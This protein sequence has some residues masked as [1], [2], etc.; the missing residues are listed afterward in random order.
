VPARRSLAVIVVVVAI[1]TALGCARDAA[2]PKLV[3]LIS[4]DTLRRDAL[5]AFDQAAMPLPHVDA[6]A[7]ESVRFE[8]A[9]SVAS[10]TLPAHASM[11]TGLGPERHG[12][13]DPRVTL[14]TEV[15]TLAERFGAAG[16]ET[17]AITH[18]GYVDRRYGFGRGF[19]S[20][21]DEPAPAK[22][23]AD[24][25]RSVFDLAAELLRTR[26]DPR[27][28]F[29]FL[30]TYSVHDYF[31]LRPWAVSQVEEQPALERHEYAE[32]LQGKRLCKPSDWAYLR[33]LYAAELRTFDAA[34]G[35]LLAALDAAGLARDAVIALTTDHGEGFEAERGR[36]HHGGRLH[37][38]VIRIPLLL[39]APGLAPRAVSTPVSLIDV[40]PT[41]LDLA[42]L[43]VPNGLDGVSLAGLAR[44]EA[45]S[46]GDR[47]LAAGEHYTIWFLDAR[48][49]APEVR[50][51]PY[52]LALIDGD[53]WYLRTGQVEEIYDVA[54]DPRQTRN[55]GE[56]APDLAA[57]RAKAAGAD[58]DRVETPRI[59]SSDELSAR[60]RALGYVE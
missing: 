31:L 12:A 10:W 49:P 8:R 15:A 58:V 24:A 32:C 16:F 18:G 26:E 34:F 43:P 19:E 7:Q 38:D 40:M 42:G 57:L 29:L 1:A 6:F 46:V 45:E 30:Q 2:L 51:R 22:T 13:T 41:L 36:I 21:A 48:T 23:E 56:G 52:S 54:A 37:E 20:Y 27:P 33:K 14:S 17:A 47:P 25:E 44:G 60:L 59:E 5:R 55:E 4:V 35:R 28:L 53:R 9:V 11:L 3:L 39:R 50:P